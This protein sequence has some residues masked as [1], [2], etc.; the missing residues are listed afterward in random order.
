MIGVVG[1]LRAA[2]RRRGIARAL[3]LI[4]APAALFG[5][6]A[7]VRAAAPAPAPT[8]SRYLVSISGAAG[9]LSRTGHRQLTL[10]VTGS[11]GHVTRFAT[12]SPLQTRDIAD[13]A[14]ARAFAHDLGPSRPNAV[15]SYTEP[16]RR[17]PRSVGLTL[18]RPR[19]NGRRRTWTFPALRAAGHANRPLGAFTHVTLLIDDADA[20][21]QGVIR[22]YEDCHGVNLAF[23][24]LTGDDLTGVDFSGADLTGANLSGAD[25]AGAELLG[26]NLTYASLTKSNLAGSDLAGVN[27]SNEIFIGAN[28][29]GANLANANLTGA[30]FAGADLNGAWLTYANLSDAD[31]SGADLTNANLSGAQSTGTD[32]STARVCDAVLPGGA[33]GTGC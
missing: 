7:A 2:G 10:R 22:P 21:G 1:G 33:I 30:E 6:A 26:A 4:A 3:A 8:T 15:L 31:F 20:C 18:G 14:F 19:W 24:D 29:S 13:G 23:D 27:L 5:P 11:P 28:L 16:E 12:R 9:T 32:L 25:L 17:I